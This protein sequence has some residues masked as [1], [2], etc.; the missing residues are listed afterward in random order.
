MQS[1]PSHSKAKAAKPRQPIVSQSEEPYYNLG[2]H[3]E[4]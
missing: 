4:L 1:I 3:E 2:L